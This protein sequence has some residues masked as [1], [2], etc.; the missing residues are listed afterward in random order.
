MANWTEEQDHTFDWYR[1]FGVSLVTS[2]AINYFT[3]DSF[4]AGAIGLGVGCLQ[5]IVLERGLDGK[6]LSCMG[7]VVGNFA[8][9]IHMHTKRERFSTDYYDNM[10]TYREQPKKWSLKRMGFIK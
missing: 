3:D 2:E 7:S 10:I 6:I 9:D 4:T 8:F 5:G 1:G